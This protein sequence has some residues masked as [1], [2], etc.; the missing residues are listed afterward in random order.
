M[1]NI[2]GAKINISIDIWCVFGLEKKFSNI[3]AGY[4]YYLNNELSSL[5]PGGVDKYVIVYHDEF[6]IIRS[7]YSISALKQIQENIL[8]QILFN[9]TTVNDVTLLGERP[10]VFSYS[11]L[12]HKYNGINVFIEPTTEIIDDVPTLVPYGVDTTTGGS[13]LYTYSIGSYKYTT[14]SMTEHEHHNYDA[15]EQIKL[16][17]SL[18]AHKKRP[19]FNFI[20]GLQVPNHVIAS[21][22]KFLENNFLLLNEE[23][24]LT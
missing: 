10:S 19:P 14:A 17:Y 5:I 8:N 13:F 4:K 7:S 1:V 22:T 6:A 3:I 2:S 21:D 12:S 18:L 16:S 9:H 20:K 11:I 23:P 24:Y 15:F